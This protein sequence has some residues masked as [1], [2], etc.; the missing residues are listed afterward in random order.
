M[1]VSVRDDDPGFANYNLEQKAFLDGIEVTSKCFT[2]DEELGEVHVYK[3]N[4]EGKPYFDPSVN[5]VPWEILRG[6]VKIVL[7]KGGS[8]A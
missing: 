5:E 2:A 3:L 7:D 1:R 4:S 8:D 6:D